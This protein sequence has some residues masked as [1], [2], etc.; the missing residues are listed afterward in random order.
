[1]TDVD[2][3]DFDAALAN[4]K[5]KHGKLVKMTLGGHV[6]L[7]R[8]F[9]KAALT[10]LRKQLS[11]KGEQHGIDIMCTA[12]GF[13]C[14]YGQEHYPGIVDDFPLAIAGEDGIADSLMEVAK[15]GAN[16]EVV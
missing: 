3:T 12:V 1:M 13:L 2:T 14:V 10:Q 5:T 15:G 7:F 6:L 9:K 11:G 8:P 16:I 4:L